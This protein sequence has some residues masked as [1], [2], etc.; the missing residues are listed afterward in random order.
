MSS[1]FQNVTAWKANIL[2]DTPTSERKLQRLQDLVK[3]R[4]DLWRDMERCGAALETAANTPFKKVCMCLNHAMIA[5]K[6]S[7]QRLYYVY[8]VR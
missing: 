2:S 7:I 8:G 5:R 3:G 6:L 4:A 1:F